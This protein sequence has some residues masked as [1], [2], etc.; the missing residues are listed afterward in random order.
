MKKLHQ[1]YILCL[2]SVI[3]LVE[4]SSQDIENSKIERQPKWLVGSDVSLAFGSRFKDV[5]VAPF[6]GYRVTKNLEI[7][8]KVPVNLASFFFSYENKALGIGLFSRYYL[9]EQLF[10]YTDYG[11]T[12]AHNISKDRADPIKTYTNKFNADFW[13]VGIGFRSNGRLGIELRM[14]YNIISDLSDLY[15]FSDGFQLQT[16]ISYKF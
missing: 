16:G 14:N 7:G 9:L 15:N 13:N 4:I 6:L 12:S 11:F 2:L 8:L 3:P 10:L 1:F 5:Q